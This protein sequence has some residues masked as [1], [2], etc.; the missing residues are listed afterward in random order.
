[1]GIVIQNY[2]STDYQFIAYFEKSIISMPKYDNICIETNFKEF[3]KK[4]CLFAVYQ[5]EEYYDFAMKVYDAYF[6][7]TYY[8]L[9]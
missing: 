9:N 6:Y 2:A 7:K 4:A 3:Y 8:N 5:E 1:M